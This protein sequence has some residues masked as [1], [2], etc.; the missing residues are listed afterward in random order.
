MEIKLVDFDSV[1]NKEGF[2][3]INVIRHQGEVHST[4]ALSL[5]GIATEATKLVGIVKVF[6]WNGVQRGVELCSLCLI[7]KLSA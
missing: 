1:K 4:M 2:N 5:C 3:F 7:F 6:A